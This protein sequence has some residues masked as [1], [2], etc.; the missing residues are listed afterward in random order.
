MHHPRPHGVSVEQVLD[1]LQSVPT[2]D[3]M[4]VQR[5]WW[6]DRAIGWL[7]P[8]INEAL[9]SLAMDGLT[10]IASAAELPDWRLTVAPDTLDD[11]LMRLA[12]ALQA[13]GVLS[14]WRDEPMDL[15]WG[16]TR[17]LSTE[18]AAFRTLGMTTRSVH[19]NGWV[20]HPDGV[21]LWV[22]ERSPHKF[23]DPG[24]WDNLVGGGVSSGE[25]LP[26]ALSREAWEEAG[27]VLKQAPR[28]TASLS[29]RRPIREGV[30]DERIA[31]YDLWL[32]PHW[33]PSNQDGEVSR[34]RRVPLPEVLS[35]LVAGRFTW[36][37]ALVIIS[38]LVQQ[39]YFGADTARIQAALPYTPPHA[40]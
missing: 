18:R 6:Q 11:T 5:L 21:Q 28:S 34:V 8:T 9:T 40:G 14:N 4:A 33:Q 39:R 30:Q 17:V 25:D 24:A 3:T 38:G 37:A 10:P 32:S 20:A 36:D 26:L 7:T 27:L 1:F 31:C 23:V 16:A 22:A 29:I 35:A 13:A 19:L 15:W 2:L 12:R